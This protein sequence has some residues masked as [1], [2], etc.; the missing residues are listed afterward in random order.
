MYE[1]SK[2]APQEALRDL[3][4]AFKNF[5]KGRAN[6]PKFKKKGVHDSFRFTGTIKVFPKHVQLPRLGKIRVKEKTT[7]CKGRILS[8]TVSREADRWYVSLTVTVEIPDPAPIVG[9]PVGIDVGLKHFAV[10]STEE[11][12]EAPKSLEKNLKRLRR[13]SQQHSKKQKGSNNRRKSAIK[14]ARLHRRI[15]NQRK[16]FLHK[17]STRLAKTKPVIVI[18]DLAVKN[19]IKNCRLSRHIADAGWGE[20]KRMLEYKTKWYESKLVVVPKFYP[21]SRM[22]SGCG[23]I[24]PDMKLS[25]RYWVCPKCGIYHDW[26]I[27]AA[28]NLV[29]YLE[30]A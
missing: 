2:C 9:E 29:N 14:L 20:F 6:F 8:T 18:E 17:L 27:N 28:Q 10:L 25:I 30:T 24:L 13:L 12:I 16:D 21:S 5:F 3:D 1:V 7:K 11:K 22:C 26:D 4:R 15:R 19:M 23:Y